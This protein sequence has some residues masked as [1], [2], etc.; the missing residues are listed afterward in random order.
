MDNDEFCFSINF[1]IAIYIIA[2]I[3]MAL[4]ILTFVFS[5]DTNYHATFHFF[6]LIG[7]LFDAIIACLIGLAIL[8][9]IV[10]EIISLLCKLH[11]LI[12]KQ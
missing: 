8:V 4:N 7:A 9:C 1:I 6:L 12:T 2:S 5:I 3:P 11:K 10:Y